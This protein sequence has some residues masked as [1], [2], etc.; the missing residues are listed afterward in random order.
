M[1]TDRESDIVHAA[2]R[3]S[4]EGPFFPDWE[5]RT[6]MGVQRE[7]MRAVLDAWPTVVDAE[8]A[9]LAINNAFNNLLGYPHDDWE[10]W[11][12]Y[13]DAEPKELAQVFMRW[14][15]ERGM[16]RPSNYFEGLS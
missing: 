14:R 11:A 3:A 2:L 7:E 15:S 8:I 4:V 6:L 10:E 13:S 1:L 16:S 5:F 9:D 12:S